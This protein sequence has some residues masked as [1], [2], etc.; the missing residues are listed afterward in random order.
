MNVTKVS[1]LNFLLEQ[2]DTLMKQFND[3]QSVSLPKATE[4]MSVAVS[5]NAK[6]SV[7]LEDVRSMGV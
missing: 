6:L 3:A 5:G 4:L 7:C 2:I 1:Q